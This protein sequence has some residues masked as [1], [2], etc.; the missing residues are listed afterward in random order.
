VLGERLEPKH[1]GG[2]CL[3]SPYVDL[4]VADFQE[5]T[6]SARR[7]PSNLI[8]DYCDSALICRGPAHYQPIQSPPW[9]SLSA[10]VVVSF[11]VESSNT[12]SL[13]RPPPHQ[14]ASNTIPSSS[15]ASALARR[16][17]SPGVRLRTSAEGHRRSGNYQIKL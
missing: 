14:L 8:W 12:S 3:S 9:P 16:S 6:P 15:F 11:A 10:H 7:S 5:S 17:R 1:V 4:V 2:S 13:A